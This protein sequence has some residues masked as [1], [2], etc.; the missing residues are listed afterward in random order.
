MNFTW[1]CEVFTEKAGTVT[2]LLPEA[3]AVSQIMKINPAVDIAFVNQKLK[4]LY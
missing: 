1:L 2:D 4:V 3:D